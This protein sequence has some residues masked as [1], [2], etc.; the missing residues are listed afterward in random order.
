MTAGRLITFEGGEGS[1]KSTQ[2]KRLASALDLRGERFLVT[3]EPGGSPG[4][5]DIRRLLVEGEPGRW[6]AITEALLVSGARRDHVERVIRPALAE[7][8][9]VLC[10]RFYDST[11]AYQG[12]GHGVAASTLEELRRIALG[13]LKPDLTFLLDLDIKTGLDRARGRGGK[14]TRFERFDRDFH[15]RVRDGFLSIARAEPER[16]H[17]INA[18]DTPDAV[19]AAILAVVDSCFTV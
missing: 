1:G 4:A 16:V 19:A 15:Q 11:S 8:Q 13:D 14:E 12:A 17:L 10:D 9:W 7:G 6:D 3:R 18:A 2:I 5:E